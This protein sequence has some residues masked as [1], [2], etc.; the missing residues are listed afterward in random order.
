MSQE[1]VEIVRASFAPWNAGDMDAYR[2]LY[3]ADA[4]LRT[5]EGWPEPGPYFG[6]EAVMREL[7]H[8]R[9]AWDTTAAEVISDFIEV[10]DRV[11]VRFILRGVGQGPGVAQEMTA[12]VTVRKGKIL[13]LEVFW[14]HAEVLGFLGLEE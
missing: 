7:E 2:D 9:S 1:N 6:R 12:L 3:D 14:D 11:A 5:P 4:V 8:M 13:A 10:A